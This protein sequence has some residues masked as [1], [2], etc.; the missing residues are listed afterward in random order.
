MCCRVPSLAVWSQPQDADWVP[1]WGGQICF[2][3][4]FVSIDINPLIEASSLGI[5]LIFISKNLPKKHRFVVNG[6]L[7]QP[8]QLLQ[9]TSNF[10]LFLASSHLPKLTKLSCCKCWWK[11][12]PVSSVTWKC[13]GSVLAWAGHGLKIWK[14]IASE[15]YNQINTTNQKFSF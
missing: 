2:L 10:S 11:T 8:C 4:F 13:I 12:A 9:H 7:D 3:L 14:K 15:I 6:D 1:L 5:K